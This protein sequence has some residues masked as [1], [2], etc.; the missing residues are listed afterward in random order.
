MYINLKNVGFQ[1]QYI[2]Y[3]DYSTVQGRQLLCPMI[4]VGSRRASV[5]VTQT[6]LWKTS[7]S[8]ACAMLR[9]F[10]ESAQQHSTTSGSN[11]GSWQ[12]QTTKSRRTQWLWCLHKDNAER[13]VTTM[14]K[15]TGVH[16][17]TPMG[18]RFPSGAEKEY[19]KLEGL[20]YGLTKLIKAIN[21][22][23]MQLSPCVICQSL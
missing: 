15:G 17:E 3:M 11:W 1:S 23:N 16:E 6:N 9:Q 4:V 18:L 8:Q 20:Q 10:S 14:K 21:K 22:L 7:G 13:K 12:K 19:R 2:N 5:Q